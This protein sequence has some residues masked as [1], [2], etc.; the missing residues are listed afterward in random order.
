MRSTDVERFSRDFD[1]H[2]MKHK[3]I[4]VFGYGNRGTPQSQNTR[5]SGLNVMI[6]AGPKEMFLDWAA[7]EKDG[8]KVLPMDECAKAGDVVH[9]LLSGQIQ[10][11]A[12]REQIH[13]N[14][15]KDTTVSFSH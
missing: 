1:P 6:G 5:D 12:Y 4:S 11:Q 7:A 9:I 15:R 10:F 8:S 3:V 13:R 2:I 14:L